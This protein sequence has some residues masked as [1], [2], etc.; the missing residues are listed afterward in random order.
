MEKR[1]VGR[2]KLA[3]PHSGMNLNISD[4]V[5]VMLTE[6]AEWG[7]TSKSA[8]VERAVIEAHGRR[9]RQTAKLEAAAAQ[10]A[11]E[12]RERTARLTASGKRKS[13]VEAAR[14]EGESRDE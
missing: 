13:R 5:R 14:G 1:K 10:V 3:K 2:P 6:L 7:E 12:T 9:T 4:D 11:A 8:W